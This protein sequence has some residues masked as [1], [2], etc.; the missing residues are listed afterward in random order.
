MNINTEQYRYGRHG[1]F[2]SSVKPTP[3]ERLTLIMPT[4]R[5]KRH[6]PVGEVVAVEPL[7]SARWIVHV[8][9]LKPVE[10]MDYQ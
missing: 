2:A 9:K 1:R 4:G 5:G 8:S 10:G 6:V 3:G 7:G